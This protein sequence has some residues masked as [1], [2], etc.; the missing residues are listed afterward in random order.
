MKLKPKE[1]QSE[2]TQLAI[3]R[4]PLAVVWIG[5]IVLCL[6][7]R[8]Q[9]TVERIINCTPDNLL[10]AAA[11]MLL[12]FALKGVTVVIYGGILYAASGIL[13]PLPHAIAVNIVG[14][15]LMTTIP[16]LMGKRAGADILL[17]LRQKNQKLELL[18]D[19]QSEN[20]FF[21]AFMIRMIGMLPGDLVGMYLGASNMR[22]SR[23]ISGTM[24]GMLPAIIAFSV[25]GTSIDDP[26]S[27]EFILSACGEAGLMLLALALYILWRRKKKQE[28]VNNC[29][30]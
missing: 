5:I 9:I 12:L 15:V 27:P 6:I 22:Y 24:L 13:F 14:T 20:A 1:K 29:G 17:Q 3:K 28:A 30:E 16:F 2:L 8:D 10:L 7:F 18:Q 11:V 21:V 19:L 4:I 25:M 26:G 23:Y